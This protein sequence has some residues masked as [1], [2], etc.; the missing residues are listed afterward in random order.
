MGFP[1]A[2]KLTSK[3]QISYLSYNIQGI[4]CIQTSSIL[5][6]KNYF[7][8]YF[9][10]Q[11]IQVSECSGCSANLTQFNQTLSKD[12][13]KPT[14]HVSYED[15]QLTCTKTMFILIKKTTTAGNDDSYLLILRRLY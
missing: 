12:K 5:R 10:N 6:V 7:G 4:I 1:L 13:L 3:R 8:E 2:H 11:P 15:K 9:E 14:F